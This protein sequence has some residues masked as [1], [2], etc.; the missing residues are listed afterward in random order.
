MPPRFYVPGADADSRLVLPEGEAHHLRHVLRLSVGDAVRIFDGRGREWAAVVAAESRR[1]VTVE[2]GAPVPVPPEPPMRVTLGIGLLKGDQMETV[3]RDATMLGV[4][5]I[6]P[7][8]SAHVAAR[9]TR[10]H[11]AA[12]E[13]WNR[14]AVASAKQCGR[15]V[16]PPVH[17]PRVFEELRPPD[18]ERV[19]MAVEP[20]Q[21]ADA[22]PG[23]AADAGARVPTAALVL[24]GPEGGWATAEVEV[25]RTWQAE[26]LVLGPRTL[27]AEV[28][29]TVLLSVLWT[30]WGWTPAS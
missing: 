20:S 21:A 1:E 16:V 15:A 26:C 11:A 24:V 8:L 13:R 4:G 17:P 12:V 9:S 22:S 7:V 14:V 3:V 29:P 27:R 19:V 28:A 30:R 25:A 5:A 23:A 2:R 10:G 18:G 6:V